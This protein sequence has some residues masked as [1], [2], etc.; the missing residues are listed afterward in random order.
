VDGQWC[1]GDDGPDPVS[2]LTDQ[3]GYGMVSVDG[4]PNER[5][6]KCDGAVNQA[7]TDAEIAVFDADVLAVKIVEES[8]SPSILATVGV[9]VR[10]DGAAAFDALSPEDQKTAVTSSDHF[11][12]WQHLRTLFNA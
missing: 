9:T 5:T 4:K 12:A 1:C 2:Y 7:R 3:V 11:A 8:H 6:Q 10:A